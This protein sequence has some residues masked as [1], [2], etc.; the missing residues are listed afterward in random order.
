M[1]T[2]N[3]TETKEDEG[4]IERGNLL[5]RGGESGSGTWEYRRQLPNHQN[6]A[7][8]ISSENG[9]YRERVSVCVTEGVELVSYMGVGIRGMD[10][11][12]NRRRKL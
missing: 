3:E 8:V 12:S 5:C 9:D 1:R 2:E 7:E 11:S 4:E 10:A 6:C